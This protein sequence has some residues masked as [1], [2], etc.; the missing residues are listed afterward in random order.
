MS[1]TKREWATGNVVGAVDLNRMEQGIANVDVGYSCSEEWVTL[2]DESVTT[3]VSEG[4]SAA[5]GGLTYSDQITAPTI[6]VTFNGT[7]YTCNKFVDG[8]GIWYGAE[9]SDA[10]ESFDFSTYPFSISS[11]GIGNILITETAGTYQVKIEA[12]EKTVETSECFKK[13]V[14][15]VRT[16]AFQVRAV[17][18]DADTGMVT[19]NCSLLQ[20][21][22]AFVR[23]DYIT[24]Y[25]EFAELVPLMLRDC[26]VGQDS[27]HPILVGMLNYVTRQSSASNSQ[28]ISIK[29]TFNVPSSPYEIL[30][31]GGGK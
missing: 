28:V 15:S 24:F 4:S 19:Y 13:A 2:T 17:S 1:Y 22:N 26:V 29:I 18:K 16:G 9:W 27:G 10:I 5:Y 6:K 11:I 21:Q 3:T 8:D 30:T 31:S 25:N 14:E 7:E 12:Y 23:G 20:L